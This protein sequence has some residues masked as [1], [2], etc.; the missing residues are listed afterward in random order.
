MPIWVEKDNPA[1]PYV[2]YH[3]DKKALQQKGLNP[4]KYRAVGIGNTDCFRRWQDLQP[5]VVLHHLACAYIDRVVGMDNKEVAG[6][7]EK[8][9][10]G[11]KYNRV[12]RF[13]GKHVRHPALLNVKEYFAE[14]SESYYG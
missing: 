4:D 3:D 9:V 10:K 14:M 12:L 7:L 5:S 11:G 6:A 2:V 13:D 1:V 8:A